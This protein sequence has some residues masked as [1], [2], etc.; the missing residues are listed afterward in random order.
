LPY[1]TPLMREEEDGKVLSAFRERG[2]S[3]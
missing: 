1:W 3:A 2:A